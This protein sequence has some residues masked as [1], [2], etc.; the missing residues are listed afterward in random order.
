LN[1]AAVAVF[2][3]ESR[4]VLGQYVSMYINFGGV[5]HSFSRR[6]LRSGIPVKFK[7]ILLS[8]GSFYKMESYSK[9]SNEAQYRAC[10]GCDY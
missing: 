6:V 1:E 8:N 9:V 2:L 3:F 4:E 7:L 5:V 10:G